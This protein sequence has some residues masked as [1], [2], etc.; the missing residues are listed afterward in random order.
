MRTS[1]KLVFFCLA[2][3]SLSFLMSCNDDFDSAMDELQISKTQS[4]KDKDFNNSEIIEFEGWVKM[5]NSDININYFVSGAEN[6]KVDIIFIHGI[7]T[8]HLSWLDQVEY[9]KTKARV[10]NINL[11][12]VGSD[13]D[14]N[15]GH[16]W[17]FQL[18]ADA[19][20]AVMKELKTKK[21]VLVGHSSGYAVCKEVVLKYPKEV[22]KVVNVDGEPWLWPAE[23]DP[24]RSEFEGFRNWFLSAILSGELL[25]IAM[26]GSCPDGVTPQD[27]YDYVYFCSYNFP[28]DLLHSL[29]VNLTLEEL[30][31][32]KPWSTPIISINAVDKPAI[33]EYFKVLHPNIQ[34]YVIPYPAGHF[35]QMEQPEWVNQVIDDFVFDKK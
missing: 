17:T 33:F 6:A 26:A 2:V 30:W 25:D 5:K 19:V 20:Y 12:Y 10:I 8:N 23:G 31:V 9:F 29:F 27:V 14:Y 16:N 21:A 22:S 28:L 13:Y 32:P 3:F 24:F 7:A 4:F 34:N 18:L 11:P 1:K 35:I 15:Y